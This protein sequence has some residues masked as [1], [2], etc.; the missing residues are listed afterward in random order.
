MHLIY[1][2]T[3]IFLRILYNIG[4]NPF[5]AE[6][7]FN[8]ETK[9]S[10]IISMINFLLKYKKLK[11]VDEIKGNLLELVCIYYYII[12]KKFKIYIFTNNFIENNDHIFPFLEYF[13]G[14]DNLINQICKYC[15][16]LTQENKDKQIK[17]QETLWKRCCNFK[18]NNKN[19]SNL[20]RCECYIS[21]YCSIQCQKYHWKYGHRIQCKGLIKQKDWFFEKY[22][23]TRIVNSLAT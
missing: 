1:V 16:K 21:F 22:D 18:C 12:I 23:I 9:K 13:Y 17:D 4:I 11:L 15:F 10:L 3:N 8:D 20:K 14:F 5:L 19:V 7:I 6:K 2:V